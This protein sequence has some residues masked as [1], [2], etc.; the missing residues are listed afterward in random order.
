[1]VV[2]G[3]K[4]KLA[5][6]SITDVS[7]LEEM[8]SDLKAISET[9]FVLELISSNQILQ[10]DSIDEII[11]YLNKSK[12]VHLFKLSIHDAKKNNV[13][14]LSTTTEKNEWTIEYFQC[15]ESLYNQIHDTIKKFFGKKGLRIVRRKLETMIP[16]YITLVI[17]SILLIILFL[18]SGRLIYP[19][20]TLFGFGLIVFLYTKFY[21]WY[22]LSLSKS[23]V[24]LD[25]KPSELDYKK[26][27]K[28]LSIWRSWGIETKV[29]VISIVFTSI[30]ILLTIITIVIFS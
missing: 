23:A 15:E 26:T 3:Y 6:G 18:N 8:L 30:S 10:F 21:E 29:T 27:N 16:M 11:E 2:K 14:L 12:I 4:E 5:V 1:M 17:S 25:S 20:G 9:T 22:I 19:L 24:Y 13:A 7:K 28:I